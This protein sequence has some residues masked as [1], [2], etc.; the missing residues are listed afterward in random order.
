V[1]TESAIIM[2]GHRLGSLVG[3]KRV[4]LVNNL[5]FNLMDLGVKFEP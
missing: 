2:L 4:F 1:L 5:L 3:E